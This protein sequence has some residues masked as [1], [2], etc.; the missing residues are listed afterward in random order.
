MIRRQELLRLIN[1]NFLRLPVKSTYSGPELLDLYRESCRKHHVSPLDRVVD[2]LSG[3]EESVE[4]SQRLPQLLLNDQ[5][6]TIA[7][8]ESLEALLKRVRYRS[9]DVSGCSLDDTTG[10][11]LFDMIEYYEATNE[12]DI[13]N[14]PRIGPRGL[15]ACANMVKKCLSLVAL[16]AHELAVPEQSARMLGTAMLSSALHT[17]KLEYCKLSGRPMSSLCCALAKNTALKEL[18]LAS[19]ELSDYDAFS[20]ATLL[21]TNRYLQY[22]D[23]SN[24]KIQVRRSMPTD[25][26][27]KIHKG[28]LSGQWGRAHRAGSDRAEQLLQEPSA[29]C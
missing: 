6:L 4:R 7:Q 14:N 29:S 2:Q 18:W 28:S 1:F 5:V 12:L 10:T 11:A 8:C 24:N 27:A 13:S 23:I 16:Y 20:I 21:K 19:N 25:P 26:R 17:L 15:Q 22:L 3:L 9:I